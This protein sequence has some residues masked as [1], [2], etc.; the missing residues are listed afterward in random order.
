MN[1]EDIV[2]WIIFTFWAVFVI[3]LIIAAEVNVLKL[4]R[5]VKGWFN[6]RPSPLQREI[7]QEEK[8]IKQLEKQKADMKRLKQVR[9]R[10]EELFR[11][12][13]GEEDELN[14]EPIEE[15]GHPR[16]GVYEVTAYE[17]HL[18]S[19]NTQGIRA[20]SMGEAVEKFRRDNPDI[21]Y[22]EIKEVI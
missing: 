19:L 10:K 1:W 22:F 3:F 13:N 18:P 17:G 14:F 15:K 6:F 4:V 9:E 21:T 11:E 8:E 5:S 20:E 16:L 12:V 7:M 2:V